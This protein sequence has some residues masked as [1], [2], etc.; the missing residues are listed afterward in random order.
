MNHDDKNQDNQGQQKGNE[1]SKPFVLNGLRLIAA[2]QYGYHL[3]RKSEKLVAATYM[4]TNLFPDSEPLRAA[5]RDKALCLMSLASSANSFS[6]REKETS[7]SELPPLLVEMISLLDVAF[8]AGILS[9]MNHGLL[10]SEFVALAG[11]IEERLLPRVAKA[12]TL[13]KDFFS[14][15]QRAGDDIDFRD[16]PSEQ[17]FELREAP[18]KHHAPDSKGHDKRHHQAHASRPHLGQQGAVQEAPAKRDTGGSKADRT[19]M[20]ISL[21]KKRDGLTI[22]DFSTVI[23][24]CSEKTIQ[25]ELLSLVEKGVLKKEGER[26]WSKYS[27]R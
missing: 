11:S 22:K 6:M 4:V 1:G 7:V 5:L 23:K 18:A 8:Y 2:D 13:G 20:I 21:L 10:R 19:T 3:Y 9:S 14:V 25:R 15:E 16:T 24:D 26:R 17:A 12:P 27:L